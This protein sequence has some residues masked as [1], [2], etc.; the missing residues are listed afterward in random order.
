MAKSRVRFP[1]GQ[2][3]WIKTYHVEFLDQGYQKM[4]KSKFGV[5]NWW[6]SIY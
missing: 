3:S 6:F 2:R 1:S 5:L 4:S